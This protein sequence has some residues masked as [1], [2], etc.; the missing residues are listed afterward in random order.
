MRRH[1]K[2]SSAGSTAGRRSPL[3]FGLLAAVLGAMLG[4]SAAPA[5]AALPSVT[6]DPGPTA[7][8]VTA[9]VSGTIDPADH[10]TYY[11]FEYSTDGATWSGFGYG[12]PALAGSGSQSVSTELT[13]LTPGTQYL[14]RLAAE[15]FI[16]RKVFSAAPNPT[17]TTLPVAPPSVSISEPTAITTNSA[18][19][20]GEINPEGTDP[21]FNVKWHFQCTPGC[22]GLEGE[23]A[24]GSSSQQVSADATALHPNTNYEV[25]LI[26]ENAGG[27]TTAGPK[28]FSTPISAP[29]ARTGAVTDRGMTGANLTGAV[30]PL[31]SLTTYRFEYG[32]T[33]AYGQQ[34]PV[35]LEGPVGS[36]QQERPVSA[37]VS[38]L[39]TGATYHYRLVATSTGGVTYGADAT[40]STR[41]SE[42]SVPRAYEQVSPREKAGGSIKTYVES[43]AS[44]DGEGI[45]FQASGAFDL[46]GVEAS[47]LLGRYLDDRTPAGWNF[48]P[49]DPPQLHTIGTGGGAFTLSTLAV[50][51]DLSHSV[52]ISRQVLAPGAIENR[53][54]YYRRDTRTGEYQ[55]IATGSTDPGV[56]NTENNRYFYG[57]SKNFST[58][59]L[60]S[61]QPLL[62]GAPEA[63]TV[64]LYRWSGGNLE[65]E[66]VLPNGSIASDGSR[67]GN[68]FSPPKRYV[69][70]DGRLV[71]FALGG[72]DAGV[73]ER[74]DG[75]TSPI[76]VSR[77]P[78]SNGS[79]QPGTPLS[80][81]S[82]GRFVLFCTEGGEP[83]TP[84][85]EQ[86]ET[87]LYRLD[88]QTGAL[89]WLGQGFGFA[90]FSTM[91]ANGETVVGSGPN[92]T[93]PYVWHD[94][95]TTQIG[96]RVARIGPER[97]GRAVFRLA[98]MGST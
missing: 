5:F 76:S 11:S 38:G 91:S 40:F 45:V 82:D 62:P 72:A 90:E 27:Q 70:E 37:T 3:L 95:V 54:N 14:V 49:L 41:G 56:F 9:Q 19:F 51:E 96:N 71:I 4:I 34:V 36:G 74:H 80:M 58:I 52:V 30:N 21:A 13:S 35:L 25:S 33:T 86:S 79:A 73:Y 97:K 23:L 16:D 53:A 46:P 75:V 50:S 66:T 63:G 55:W 43:Q 65:F 8:Y 61:D 42:P 1:A 64:A 17:F 78:G 67:F 83:L 20:S 32:S 2:A 7:S 31:G 6:I 29:L 81:S 88:R 84:D 10:D 18:H 44:P 93:P 98:P 28:A 92:V 57:G 47:P 77:L 89:V 85:A 24:A 68:T 48:H 39:Q 87:G 15:N 26:A 60:A 22:P 69:S 12:G 59:I 94:G